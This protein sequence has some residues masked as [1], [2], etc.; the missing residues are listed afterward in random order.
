MSM[1]TKSSVPREEYHLTLKD[2]NLKSTTMLLNGCPL[3]LTAAG[4]IP[5]LEPK[6]VDDSLPLIV[7][8][9]SIV[10]V[11]LKGF[12]APACEIH[13]PIG[14]LPDGIIIP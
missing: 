12:K 14:P 7:G 9:S 13:S 8:P 4:D 2:G 3:Q 6:L 1:K 5:P 10:F 11:T